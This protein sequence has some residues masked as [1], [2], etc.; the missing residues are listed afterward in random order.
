PGNPAKMWC[1][2]V[3]RRGQDKARLLV[4]IS[5]ALTLTLS[6]AREH[7]T[8]SRI[9]SDLIVRR[10]PLERPAQFGEIAV[11]RR[12]FQF[13]VRQMLFESD[14]I[15]P[16][17]AGCIVMADQRREFPHRKSSLVQP[18]YIGAGLLGLLR[19]EVGAVSCFLT[20]ERQ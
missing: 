19:Y 8:S 18:P 9:G 13:F 3:A 2:F 20:A 6:L 1:F 4:V 12:R 11:D 7:H 15:G 16:C 14:H 10:C 17:D 5:F